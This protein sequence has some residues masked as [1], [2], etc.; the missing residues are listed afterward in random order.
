MTLDIQRRDA[1]VNRPSQTKG[2]WLSNLPLLRLVKAN[3][4]LDPRRRIGAQQNLRLHRGDFVLDTLRKH[5][6]KGPALPIFDSRSAIGVQN[7][8]FIKN[9]VGDLLFA[10]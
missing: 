2:T 10:I 3:E 1:L 9:R 4:N 5:A 8:T 7:I 6:A